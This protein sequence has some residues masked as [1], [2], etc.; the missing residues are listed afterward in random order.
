M[1]VPTE[2]EEVVKVATPL[3]FKLTF[4]ARVVPPSVKVAVP[5][6]VPVLGA[7]A[8]TVAVNVTT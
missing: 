4:A 5:V 2:R 3:P 7:T 6:G 1:L 8:D